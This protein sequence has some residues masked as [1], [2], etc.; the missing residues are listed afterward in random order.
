M[1]VC[2]AELK[3][4]VPNDGHRSLVNR[5]EGSIALVDRGNVSFAIKARHAQAAGAL[6]VLIKDDGSCT[7][8]FDC[9]TRLGSKMD[10]DLASRDDRTAWQGIK[11]PVMMIT[12]T[13]AARILSLL[14][15]HNAYVDGMGLQWYCV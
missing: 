15:L 6:A 8:D 11:I 3:Y 5:M 12:N 9:G 4:A 2:V 1:I 13:S 7:D 10:G 14:K